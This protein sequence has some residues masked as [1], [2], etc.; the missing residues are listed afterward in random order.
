MTN[1]VNADP[2]SLR[3]GMPVAVNFRGLTDEWAAPVFSPVT[4]TRGGAS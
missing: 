3:V 1:V 4:S 2:E